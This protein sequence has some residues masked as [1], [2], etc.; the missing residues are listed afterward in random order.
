M[1]TAAALQR[2]EV[3][4]ARAV[5]AARALA[6]QDR[7][8]AAQ[9]QRDELVGNPLRDTQNDAEMAA[10]LQLSE[11]RRQ[12]QAKECRRQ[13]EMSDVTQGMGTVSVMGPTASSSADNDEYDI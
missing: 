2:E 7:K 8:I 4:K 9:L 3:R 1:E 10:A 11:R 5:L 12:L 13:R 6:V